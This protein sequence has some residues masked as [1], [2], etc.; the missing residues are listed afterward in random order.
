MDHW[1]LKTI[2]HIPWIL[3][4]PVTQMLFWAPCLSTHYPGACMLPLLPTVLL[5]W[6]FGATHEDESFL[7][8][9]WGEGRRRVNPWLLSLLKELYWGPWFQRT[10]WKTAGWMATVS[11]GKM[12]HLVE[13]CCLPQTPNPGSEFVPHT[14]LFPALINMSTSGKHT[15]KWIVDPHGIVYTCTYAHMCTYRC[16]CI[17]T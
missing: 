3:A 7:G 15:P 16:S 17:H 10:W 14:V 13:S 4:V 11:T 1:Y 5:R 2:V 8:W 9:L 12:G 6:G